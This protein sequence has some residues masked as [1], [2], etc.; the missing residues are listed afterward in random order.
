M[1]RGFK[2][3][4]KLFGKS[5]YIDG[6]CYLLKT[7][8]NEWVLGGHTRSLVLDL[9]NLRCTLDI[10]YGVTELA[11]EHNCLKLRDVWAGDHI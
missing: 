3:N 4:S 7:L 8:W 9:E 5:N 1:K 6:S 11:V 2:E 10:S